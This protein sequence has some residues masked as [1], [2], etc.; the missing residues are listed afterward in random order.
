MRQAFRAGLITQ[1]VNS[2]KKESNLPG[3]RSSGWALRTTHS[4]Q[5]N[6]SFLAVEDNLG[7]REEKKKRF[8]SDDERKG[9]LWCNT[10]FFN[11]AKLILLF[12]NNFLNSFERFI[13]LKQTYPFHLYDLWNWWSSFFRHNIFVGFCVGPSEVAKYAWFDDGR[14]IRKAFD[15]M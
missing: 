14:W 8:G 15:V 6:V 2:E 7:W 10:F 13:S 3:L 1:K 12:Y 5:A 9:N 11:R 4:W